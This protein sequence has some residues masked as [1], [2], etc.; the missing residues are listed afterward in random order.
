[1][2]PATPS[3]RDQILR[4]GQ[5]GKPW[6]FLPRAAQF[7]REGADAETPI[8]E[9]VCFLASASLA[10]LGLRTLALEQLAML[11]DAS[12]AHPDVG[13]LESAIRRL[14]DDRFA[15]VRD[16]TGRLITPRE[17]LAG[18]LDAARR[19]ALPLEEVS[20]RD[21]LARTDLFAAADANLVW[22]V[23]PDSGETGDRRGLVGL[24]GLHDARADAKRIAE[25]LAGQVRDHAT[26][27]PIVLE[28]PCP[29]WALLEARRA[30]PTGPD[31]RRSRLTVLSRD[32]EATLLALAMADLRG[33]LDDDR[34]E[35]FVG[36]D[37]ADRFEA[38]LRARSSFLSDGPIIRLPSVEQPIEPDPASILRA[39]REAR[40]R[41]EAHDRAA[42]DASYADRNGAHWADRF[43][44]ALSGDA[45]PL[46]VLIPTCRYSTYIRHAS[47]DL[48]RAIERAGHRARI[49][50]EP[51]DTSP[52]TPAAYLEAFRAFE[53]D[54]VVLINY[55]RASVGRDLIPDSVPFVC[56]V[57]D[58]MPHLFDDALGRAHTDLD[59]ICGL[60][61]AP[62][63][64]EHGYPIDRAL[65][66]PV[67]ADATKFHAEPIDADTRRRFACHIAFVTHHSETPEAMFDRL[68]RESGASGAVDR[69][70]TR[71][72]EELP[73]IVS[74]AHRDDHRRA[75]T[76]TLA[77]LTKEHLGEPDRARAA[78]MIERHIAL[79]LFDRLFRHQ[80]LAWAHELCLERG[81]TL[82]LYGRGWDRH[83]TLARWAQPPIEHG[84]PL[85][86]AYQAATVNLQVNAT[87]MA[88]QRVFECALSGGIPAC[89]L[90]RAAIEDL[91][92]RALARA[93]EQ[94][95]SHDTGTLRGMTTR[96][97]SGAGSPEAMRYTAL[98][99]RL[100]LFDPRDDRAGDFADAGLFITDERAERLVRTAPLAALEQDASWILGDPAEL[101]FHDK[102]SLASLVERAGHP[103]WRASVSGGLRGRTADRLT[104]DAMVRRLLAFVRD[105]LASD[106]S[107]GRLD[108]A[109]TGETRSA[110]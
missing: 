39:V 35:W 98:R 20:A 28:G 30:T 106:A 86:A 32:A 66:L 83:P 22:R 89:R 59:F 40:A 91:R 74:R 71:L 80:S 5:V 18:N 51:D 67:V 47:A 11:P 101:S 42:V 78:A 53:P 36:P 68:R 23:R 65:P 19:R 95:E 46:R 48:A 87:T 14:P 38:S 82:R 61:F 90:Y 73:T 64:T 8:D 94:G 3:Q 27:P 50:A 25:A 84:E 100:G 58:P 2:T 13:A 44:R 31:G 102:P 52:L 96:V 29:P 9:A 72:W 99:Q 69:V 12:R 24:R 76:A 1:M 62:L 17:L 63:F 37:A 33:V 110:A 10:R 103:G 108:R 77:R 21:L 45:D 79:P 88:H 16:E 70:I 43:A 34:V 104:H 107:T 60:T 93:I 105:R 15:G 75:I 109:D 7:L 26:R 49:L 41:V 57:Q 85:R 97:Y 92:R 6:E 81:W 54:L 4:L 56:W 55:P